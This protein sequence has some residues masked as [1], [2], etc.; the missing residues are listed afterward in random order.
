M[1]EET[2][3][4]RRLQRVED[5]ILEKR[6]EKNLNTVIES[7]NETDIHK[8][9]AKDRDRDLSSS[10]HRWSKFNFKEDTPDC[11]VGNSSS[12]LENFAILPEL[13]QK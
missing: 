11:K 4:K 2:V 6:Q 1:D 3:Q 5:N 9:S 13:A 8:T 10:K 12:F 7:V